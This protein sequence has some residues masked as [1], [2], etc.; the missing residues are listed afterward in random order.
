[1]YQLPK[2]LSYSSLALKGA[3]Y[4]FSHSFPG[5]LHHLS[6]RPSQDI[7]RS[8]FL[9]NRSLAWSCFW[10]PRPLDGHGL[11]PLGGPD[12]VI[13]E[14]LGA[15]EGSIYRDHEFTGSWF[16]SMFRWHKSGQITRSSAVTDC[17][18]YRTKGYD[19]FLEIT[20][21]WGDLDGSVAF[22]A[23]PDE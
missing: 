18:Y 5:G 12:L 17:F 22:L 4:L 21:F 2:K 6:S 11:F 20:M 3:R 8:L 9:V 15:T 10:S 13:S 19:F 16:Q 14:G 1:M 23:C 7:P